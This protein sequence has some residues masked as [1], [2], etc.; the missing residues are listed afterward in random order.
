MEASQR[1]LSGSNIK[2]KQ[3]NLFKTRK[4]LRQRD[5]MSPMLFNLVGDVLTRM[6]AKAASQGLVRGLASFLRG[7]GVISLQYA[8]DTI[9]FSNIEHH[10]LKNPKWVLALLEQISGMRINFHKI[11]LILI[12]LEQSESIGLRTSFLSSARFPH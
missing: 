3:Y 1:W 10:H 12:N 7:E 4:G 9:L 8:N 6:L 2:W 5:P 11:E